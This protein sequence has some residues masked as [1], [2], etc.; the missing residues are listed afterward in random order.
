MGVVRSTSGYVYWIQ[1]VPEGPIK[2]G[3]AVNPLKRLGELQR[4]SPVTLTLLG[5]S[6]GSLIEE[7]AFHRTL[8]EHRLHG[9][10]FLPCSDVLESVGSENLTGASTLVLWMCRKETRPQGALDDHLI[11]AAV[12]MSAGMKAPPRPKR[13]KPLPMEERWRRAVAL[14][15][16]PDE[17]W[18]FLT[19]F[20]KRTEAE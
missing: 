10:W 8:S 6:R 19:T 18:R 16:D 1:A 17:A 4:M 11:N 3:W 7:K 13:R 14:G 9:E 20:E 5:A 15:A 12:L 2:I